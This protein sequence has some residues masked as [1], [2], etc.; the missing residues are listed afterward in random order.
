M[1]SISSPRHLVSQRALVMMA[2]VVLA[3]LPITRR[4]VV[5][6]DSQARVTQGLLVLYTFDGPNSGII[7]D[8]SDVG[9]PLNLRLKKSQGVTRRNGKFAV[10]TSTKIASTGPATKIVDAVKKSGELT[11]EAWI[12][13]QDDRQ[14]GPARIVSLSLDPG[15]RNFTLGQDGNR[16]DVRLRTTATDGNGN[17]STKT[18]AGTLKAETT[19]VVFTRGKSGTTRIYLNGKQEIAG[20]ANGELSGWSET[21]QLSVGNELTGDRPWLGELELVAIYD[22][23][24]PEQDI[25]QNFS[26]GVKPAVD[27]AALLPPGV[28]RP[29]DFVKDVQPI[30]RQHCFECHAKGNEE[31]GLNLGI[32]ARVFEGSQNGAVIVRGNSAESRLVHSVAGIDED[33]VMPPEGDR[34]TLEQVGILRAWIDQG[35]EWPLGADVLDPRTERARQHWAFQPLHPVKPPEVRNSGWAITPVDHF[36]LARLEAAGLKPSP[37]LSARGFARRVTFDVIGLPPTPEAIAEYC[38]AAERDPQTATKSLVDRLLGSQHYGERWGRHWL[39]VARYADSDGQES[40]QDRPN[41]YHYRDFVIRALNE[42]LPF[43]TFVR[44]QLAGDEYEPQNPAAVSATGFLTAGTNV[45]LEEKHLEEERLRNRYNELD[46]VLTTTGKAMLA[47]TIGCARCHDHKYDAISSREYYRLLSAFHSG[48]R[49]EVPLGSSKEKA[50]AFRDF[51]PEPKTTWLFKR[52]DFYNREQT[53]QLGVLDVLLRGRTIEDYSATA[54]KDRPARQ[55]TYQRRA[56]AEWMTDADHGAGPL[57]ARV[58]VNRVWQHHF[59]EGLVRTVDDF[60]TR[61][62]PPSHPELLE[63]LAHDFV[64]HGWK[65]KRLQHLLLT[66]ATYRQGTKIDLPQNQQDPENRLLWRMRPHRVEA[67]ILR[68]SMLAVSGM[69]NL[70]PYGPAFKPPIAREA[71]T[72]RNLKTPYPKDIQ[73]SPQVRRRSIYMFHKR[74]I[75]HPMLQLFDR[76]DSLQSCGRRDTTIVAPQA[77]AM[78]NDVFVRDCAVAFAN[79][80]WQE[81]DHDHSLLIKRAFELALGRLP[82]DLESRASLAFLQLQIKQQMTDD[83]KKSEA[84]ALRLALDDFCQSIFSVN[85]FIYVD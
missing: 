71:M 49:A 22:R 36:I 35:A 42:D 85:E 31:G 28:K 2:M 61:S 11:I 80:L 29:V 3:T 12:R 73:D 5:A 38:D 78:L 50:L 68:D 8:R 55:S 57:L 70:E 74:V 72:A 52:G 63:W 25:R 51:G 20:Q 44:W 67:E 41:A 21:F 33:L 76:P 39:D 13:P 47:L 66:S 18:A 32:K 59:G 77:L 6:N 81:P 43:D 37:P 46:D 30:L 23:E 34:L 83:A 84:D 19:H 27:Y 53:V 45:M 26:A 60:G 56:L 7:E 24:L 79:R 14:A 75:P 48:D 40:D 15:Q 16:Y 62:D 1:K 17:P 82:N 58:I 10:T 69:I 54:L 64:Q 4:D 9:K 65:L